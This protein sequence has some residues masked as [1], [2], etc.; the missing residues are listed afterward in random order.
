MKKQTKYFAVLS[1]AAIMAL[2]PAFSG[3]DHTGRVLA[4]SYGW[5]E[6]NGQRPTT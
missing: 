6:E 2:T 5:T 4:A 3:L 1:A